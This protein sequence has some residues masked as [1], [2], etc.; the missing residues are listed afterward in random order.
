MTIIIS[1]EHKV[2]KLEVN[3]VVMLRRQEWNCSYCGSPS[4][5]DHTC[6][7]RSQTWLDSF[8]KRAK[9]YTDQ[10]SCSSSLYKRET[11]G[12]PGASIDGFLWSHHEKE[13]C[14]ARWNRMEIPWRTARVRYRRR[15]ST[16]EH[17]RQTRLQLSGLARRP[18]VERSLIRFP[19][20]ITSLASYA[21]HKWRSPSRFGSQ[22]DITT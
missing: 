7:P 18:A 6:R 8:A 19:F 13:I 16:F 2:Y 20:W 5:A 1:E 3:V 4:E 11:P 9:C 17:G 22:W 21:L 15:H 12:I 10:N 14:A